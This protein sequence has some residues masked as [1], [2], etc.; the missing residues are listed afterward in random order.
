V[1]CNYN[2]IT[3]CI[4]HLFNSFCEEVNVVAFFK[5][6]R[7]QTIGEVAN[8]IMYL[9]A[10]NFC[11]QQWKNYYKQLCCRKEA[12]WCFVSV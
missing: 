4:A 10:D 6:V 1:L 8:P 2:E 12:A 9:W 3:A 7:Q 5:V 11:L